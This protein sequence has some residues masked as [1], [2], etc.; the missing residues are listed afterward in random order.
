MA[1]FAY[2]VL[3]DECQKEG[4][5]TISQIR[6][7]AR[8]FEPAL[9]VAEKLNGENLLRV[10]SHLE[11]E[12]QKRIGRV[13]RVNRGGDGSSWEEGLRG[14]EIAGDKGSKLAAKSVESTFHEPD[15]ISRISILRSD[16][17]HVVAWLGSSVAFA[18]GMH[19]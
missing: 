11:K 17:S 14:D 6:A 12:I 4:I 13:K 16:F 8:D 15:L 7:M 1:M 5:D 18:I 9:A 3:H 2:D 10:M 19:I